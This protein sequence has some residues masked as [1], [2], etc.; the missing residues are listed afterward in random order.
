MRLPAAL[1]FAVWLRLATRRAYARRPF[2]ATYP[3]DTRHDPNASVDPA[4]RPSPRVACSRRTAS[5]PAPRVRRRLARG[6][7]IPSTQRAQWRSPTNPPRCG[8][9][10]WGV[11]CSVRDS[12]EYGAARGIGPLARTRRIE[13]GGRRI[14][15]D[16]DERGRTS[17][18]RDDT[19]HAC[20]RSRPSRVCATHAEPQANRARAPSAI[21]PQSGRVRVAEHGTGKPRRT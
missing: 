7:V 13:P 3:G 12:V 21:E 4:P 11:G 1:A 20:R 19:G 17:V 14:R 15:P 18:C 10:R 9:S 2:A 6:P 8:H 16:L 5:P